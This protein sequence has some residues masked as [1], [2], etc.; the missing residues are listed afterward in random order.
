MTIGLPT[1]NLVIYEKLDKLQKFIQITILFL[2]QFLFPCKENKND[3][4][5][6]H[7]DTPFIFK[8]KVDSV[9][10]LSLMILDTKK[11]SATKLQSDKEVH[12][13]V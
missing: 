8:S 12:K 4:I 11:F 2:F 10:N 7:L 1:R 3:K 9:S 5:L 6:H 13:F